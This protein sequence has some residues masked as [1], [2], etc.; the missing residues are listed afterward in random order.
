MSEPYARTSLHT[1]WANV[2][3]EEVGR[4]DVGNSI[5]KPARRK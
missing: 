3:G 4:L 2:V 5:R 1:D